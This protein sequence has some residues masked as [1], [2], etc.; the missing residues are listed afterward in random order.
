MHLD[1]HTPRSDIHPAQLQPG[2][3]FGFIIYMYY[4]TAAFVG[5]VSDLYEVNESVGEVEVF[6]RRYNGTDRT[7]TILVSTIS[8]SAEGM[9]FRFIMNARISF[10]YVYGMQE[11]PR[12]KRG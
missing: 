4:S 6:V 9:Y 2:V 3:R 11:E 10:V 5:F 7:Y 12:G 1:K 8:G